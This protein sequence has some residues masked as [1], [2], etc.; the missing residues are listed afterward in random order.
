MYDWIRKVFNFYA[1]MLIIIWLAFSGHWE[2]LL[3][4]IGILLVIISN[5]IE[6]IFRV[7]VLGVDRFVSS[8]TASEFRSGH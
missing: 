4:A 3:G 6:G 5:S 1:P 2:W 7:A 8:D